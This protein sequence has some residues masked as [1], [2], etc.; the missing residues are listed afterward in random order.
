MA[1]G[2]CP[3]ITSSDTLRRIG[4]HRFRTTAGSGY[5]VWL[6]LGLVFVSVLIPTTCV[7]WFMSQAVRNERLAV[8]Q[9]LTDIY[10][11]QLEEAVALINDWLAG[12][13][14]GLSVDVSGEPASAVFARIV[15]S[16]E[17]DSVIV[18]DEQGVVHYP[19]APQMSADDSSDLQRWDEAERL[20]YE[21]KDWAGAL[22]TYQQIS[23]KSKNTDIEAQSLLAQ[24]RC[25]YRLERIDEAIV[26]LTKDLA[27]PR[28]RQARNRQGRVIALNA[29]LLAVGLME[30]TTSDRREQALRRL[31]ERIEDYSDTAIP[32]SQRRFL[33]RR[34]GELIGAAHSFPTLAA[35]DLATAYLDAR[36]VPL[37]QEP[38][39]S[40]ANLNLW[41]L[42][43]GNR[44]L[45]GL[46]REDRI[47]SEVELLLHSQLRLS[48]A[49]VQ[50]VMPTNDAIEPTPFM[51]APAG[52]LLSEWRLVLY[53]A[54]PDPFTAAADRQVAAYVWTG[55]MG[56]SAI[57]ILA[58]LVGFLVRRQMRLAGLKNDLIATVSHELKTPLASTRALVDTLR[59]GHYRDQ[60]QVREY[61]GLI[62]K[63]NE[64][65]S[66]LIDNF[67]AFSR[68]ERNKQAFERELLDV[69]DI[70]ETA[71]ESVRD[72]FEAADGH[73]QVDVSEGLPP[74][75]GDKDALVTV[76][77]NLL[78]NALKYTDVDKRISLRAIQDSDDVCLEVTDNGVGM[79]KRAQRRVFDRFYQVDQRLSRSAGGCGLGLSI[80]QFIVDAHNGSID[81]KSEPGRGSTFTV[82]LPI[83]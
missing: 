23:R 3:V 4:L 59:A 71:V 80:V 45:I 39:A 17:F 11:A 65:L 24:A 27:D 16:G 60:Q 36:S 69:R 64:R 9:K 42:I 2:A 31:T 40:I 44:R 81:V 62:A 76:L 6:L 46:L 61:Y 47:V 38:L 37:S 41:Q 25:L 78:D 67:L 15:R 26:I 66:R 55:T 51:I 49:S 83:E 21:A 70:V 30:N 63:E 1:R 72:R 68:M 79:T 82:K 10:R 54:G 20:E 32:A 73:L 56:I 77:L 22:E 35:E 48:D 43:S 28:Y 33:M 29:L 5:G 52:Q 18:L 14:D 34:L 75:R 58:L 13:Q 74:V 50:L 19:S 7:V 8:R 12:K 57:T 53:L